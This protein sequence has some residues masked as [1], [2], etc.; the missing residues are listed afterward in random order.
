MVFNRLDCAFSAER[1]LDHGIFVPCRLLL[2]ASLWGDWFAS[3]SQSSW[4]AEDD[5]GPNFRSFLGMSA[6]FHVFGDLFSLMTQNRRVVN[7]ERLCRAG[8]RSSCC[9]KLNTPLT[10]FAIPSLLNN[11]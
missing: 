9:V 3:K 11:K 5:F 10:Y 4:A 6:F 2:N 8:N 7:T 1:V